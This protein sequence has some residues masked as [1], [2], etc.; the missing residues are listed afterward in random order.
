MTAGIL[1]AYTCTLLSLF[2]ILTLQAPGQSMINDD[3]ASGA[4]G[5]DTS[6]STTTTST[7]DS[8]A[9]GNGDSHAKIEPEG[10]SLEPK[11]PED[12]TAHEQL[13]TDGTAMVSIAAVHLHACCV[14]TAL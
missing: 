12:S 14:T 6:T 9:N 10:A 13:G 4:K 3:N 8:S 2:N 5:I 7:K 11:G 1:R